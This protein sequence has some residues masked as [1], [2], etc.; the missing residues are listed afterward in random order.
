MLRDCRFMTIVSMQQFGLS[1]FL[2]RPGAPPEELG[3]CQVRPAVCCQ[4]SPTRPF[5]GFAVEVCGCMG[6]GL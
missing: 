2:T 5:Y 6:A 3:V 1:I 4:A